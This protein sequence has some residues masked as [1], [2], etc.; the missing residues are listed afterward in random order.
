MAAVMTCRGLSSETKIR[1]V[2]STGSDFYRVRHDSF[3]QK[4]NTG[5]KKKTNNN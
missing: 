2:C 1:K 5:K 4:L 3:Y